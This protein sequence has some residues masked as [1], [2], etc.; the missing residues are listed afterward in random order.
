MKSRGM[1]HTPSNSLKVFKKGMLSLNL[2]WIRSG[3]SL[4]FA[5]TGCAVLVCT[6]PW[7]K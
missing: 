2:V 4:D 3:L 5:I 6:P 7:G 1:V